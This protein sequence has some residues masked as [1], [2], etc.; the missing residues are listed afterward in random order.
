[1]FRRIAQ[2]QSENVEFALCTVTAVSGSSPAKTGMK[3][4]VFAD[5]SIEGSV[6]GGAFEK[7]C[8]EEAIGQ[9]KKG[10][11]AEFRWALSDLDMNCGGSVRVY[12]EGVVNKA[13]LVI[14]GVGHI[15]R[16]LMRILEGSDEFDVKGFDNRRERIDSE[17]QYDIEFLADYKGLSDR[18]R[19]GDHVVVL[20]HGH[21]FDTHAVRECSKVDGLRY[22]GCIGSRSKVAKMKE[23]LIEEGVSSEFLE[24][25]YTPIGLDIGADSPFEIAV[26]IIAELISVRNTGGSKCSLRV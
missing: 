26:A 18:L 9:I 20:T 4:I 5:G 6:G 17:K 8:I 16:Q 21:E 1:M 3:M 25:L 13:R 11:C 22:I 2:L 10:R 14:V 23:K 12:I 24:R 19:Y 7:R 15:G